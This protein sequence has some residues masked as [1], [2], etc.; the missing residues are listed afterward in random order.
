MMETASRKP[1]D[2]LSRAESQLLIGLA[3]ASLAFMAGL[4]V[5]PALPGHFWPSLGFATGP[6]TH[7]RLVRVAAAGLVGASLAIAGVLLQGLLRNPLADPYILG[8]SSGATAGVMVWILLGNMLATVALAHPWLGALFVYGQAVP[9]LIGAL[10]TCGAVFFLGRRG[11][12]LDP[13]TLLLA[14]VVLGSVNTALIMLLN[15]MAPYGA[16]AD[17]LNY[18]FGYISAVT[19]QFL[20]WLEAG[21]LLACWLA[22]MAISGAMNIASLSDI[23]ATS[24]GVRLSRL[25]LGSFLISAALAAGAIVL[26]GPVGFVGLICPH[27]CRSWFGPDHRRLLISSPLLG[28]A[29]L[30]LADSFVRC[31]GNWFNGEL[32]VGV[33]TA[34]CG[35]PFFLFLLQRRR[36]WQ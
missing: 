24:L 23:E 35:G 26:A 22:A 9:A 13:V 19:P 16:R 5:G 3:L 18:I 7:L 14:G 11:G 8:I 20:L 30:M 10:F 17:I 21:L 28:A 1:A 6:A 25:R 4:A 32:P 15:N 31:T 12:I 2:W 34:L 33:V 29:F 27:I 36:P